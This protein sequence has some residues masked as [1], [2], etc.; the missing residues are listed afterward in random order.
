MKFAF[1]FAAVAAVSAAMLFPA[2][3]AYAAPEPA[4][5]QASV[6]SS[7]YRSP[8]HDYRPLGEEKL[9]PWKATNDEVARIGGWRAY[10]KEASETASAQPTTPADKA[11]ATLSKPSVADN[12]HS[13]H[14]RPGQP[15]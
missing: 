1:P 13:G 5:S 14:Q 9:L 6:A 10:A 11:P 12:P 4:D 2:R 7:L 8:F 15:K 3:F